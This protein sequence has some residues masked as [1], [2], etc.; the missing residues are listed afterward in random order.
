MTFPFFVIFSLFGLERITL[1]S[2]AEFRVPFMKQS[3][4]CDCEMVPNRAV[5]PLVWIA[6]PL[7]I[8]ATVDCSPMLYLSS[9]YVKHLIDVNSPVHS[10][11][12]A[13]LAL[14]CNSPIL[15]FLGSIFGTIQFALVAPKVLVQHSC[16][17]FF[18]FISYQTE[19]FLNMKVYFWQ[20]FSKANPHEVGR[21]NLLGTNESV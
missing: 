10:R 15:S 4:K 18:P 21:L 20:T 11:V 17:T 2:T 6:V 3:H 1:T 5:F 7:L 12:L 19:H 13:G 8:V 9:C 14:L 16:Q